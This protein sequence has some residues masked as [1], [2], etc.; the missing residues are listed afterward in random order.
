MVASALGRP[1][2]LL[3]QDGSGDMPGGGRPGL[4]PRQRLDAK[5]ARTVRDGLSTP[6]E[7]SPPVRREPFPQLLFLFGRPR[8]RNS[9]LPILVPASGA[10]S[11]SVT[12]CSRKILTVTML[13]RKCVTVCVRIV[14]KP[15]LL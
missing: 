8:I 13:M 11:A 6:G 4:G 1:L 7:F 2:N 15:I 10:L 14:R 9:A 12:R 3:S 5:G